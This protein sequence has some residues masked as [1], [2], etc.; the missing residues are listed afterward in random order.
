MTKENAASK[1]KIWFPNVYSLL[2]IL[3]VAAAALTWVIPS[4][5]FERV[6]EGTITKVIPGTFAAVDPS[7]QGPWKFFQAIVTGFKNQA[8]L[9]YMIFFVG[10]AVYMLESTKAIDAVFS[11]LAKAVKGKEEIAVFCVMAFMSFGGATGVFGNVTLVLVPIGIFLSL[12]MGFDKT[13]GFF[14]IFFGSFSGF[15]VGWANAGT[16]GIAQTIAELP[17]FSGLEARVIMHLVNFLLSYGFVILYLKQIK[18]DPTRSLNYKQGMN[19]AEYMGNAESA[20]S[21]KDNKVT[22]SQVLS[23]VLMFGGILSVIV[24]AS[25]FKW[26]A[27]KIS[28][29]FLVVAILIGFVS[30]GDFNTVMDHFIQGCSRMVT[31]AFIVGFANAI[32]VLMSNG[33]ILDTIVYY[34]S[35][36]IN[37]FGPVIGAN[38]ML[39]VNVLINFFISSGSGQASA[40]MPIM[41]PIA[42]LTGITRQVAVQAY[43][44]GDGFTN[45]IIPT[46]GTLMGGLGFAGLGYGKYLKKVVW[47]ILIQILL[48]MAAITILQ[49]IGWTGL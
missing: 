30:Y 10:A 6:T 35:I 19:L 14:M 36:P 21:M 12:A 46:V 20:E 33:K 8:S 47:L 16:I 31:A 5:S 15:N 37:H 25:K 17:M 9:I 49:S 26:G 7:H 39:L 34:L 3:A 42:D 43:Q 22:S 48:A 40:V 11:R 27:D 41:V 18:K 1:K 13:L 24:G 23:M 29:A 28:A 45:C 44:F 32:T 38:I 2:V 4:G